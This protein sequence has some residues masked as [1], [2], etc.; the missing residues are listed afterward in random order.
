M[1]ARAHAAAALSP[2]QSNYRHDVLMLRDG[3]AADSGIGKA[4]EG[5]GCDLPGVSGGPAVPANSSPVTLGKRCRRITLRDGS[6]ADSGSGRQRSGAAAT[7]PGCPLHLQVQVLGLHG[8]GA[9]GLQTVPRRRGGVW[10]R[11]CSISS[12]GSGQF[13]SSAVTPGPG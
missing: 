5:S 7:Y 4:E 8:R 12:Y 1:A 3:S 2:R 6:A 11:W 10:V 13:W 9:G